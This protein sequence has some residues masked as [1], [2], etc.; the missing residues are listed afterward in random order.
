MG[1]GPPRA[2]P[3]GRSVGVISSK[4]YVFQS[5]W[6]VDAASHDVFDVLRDISTYTAWWPE[7]KEVWQVDDESVDVRARALL[8]Y[9]LRF[10][11]RR[12][13]VDE[14]AGVI[15]VGMTGDLE[16]FSRFTVTGGDQGSRVV[17]DE[18]VVTNKPLL[19]V[20]A[21][22][23]RP[24]FRFNHTLMMRHGLQGLR[25]YLAGFRRGAGS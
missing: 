21:P 7:I 23:A 9:D 8:P 15:E 2:C 10:T 20:L 17:F 1:L 5:I 22:V 6:H 13:R 12:T 18:E 11:M 25:T 24:A 16:G 3:G 14:Q 19:N 4:K